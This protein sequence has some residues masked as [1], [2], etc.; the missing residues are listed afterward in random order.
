MPKRLED[1]GPLLVALGVCG[2]HGDTISL[3]RE[4]SQAGFLPTGDGG[5]AAPESCSGPS[6]AAEQ[7]TPFPADDLAEPV[8][9]EPAARLELRLQHLPAAPHPRLHRGKREVHPQ[10]DFRQGK[11]LQ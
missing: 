1:R 8:E 5:V 7:L 11:S 3:Y 6:F 4:I 9:L 2:S 10:R